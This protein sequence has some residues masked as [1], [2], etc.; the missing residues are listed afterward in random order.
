MPIHLYWG[1]DLAALQAAVDTLQHKVLD[2][3]W[4]S[5]N[6]Q[7]VD[8][9]DAEAVAAAFIAVRT[10]PFGA[11]GR[12]VHVQN[13]PLC[14][15]C[16]AELAK[17]L[18]ATLPRIPPDCHL[19]L[20]SKGKPDARLKT[21]K[22]LQKEATVK[23]FQQP[24]VWDTSGQRKMVQQAVKTAGL[25]IEP[26]AVDALAEAIGSDSLRLV[27][28]LEKLSLHAAGGTV[29]LAA[30]RALV[31]TTSQTS[32]Q[33]GEALLAND[34]PNVLQLLDE[35]LRANEPPLRIH[36]SLTAQV[37]GWLWV[38]V[39]DAAGER[40]E[41]QIAKAAGI[42]NPRRVYVLRRQLGGRSPQQV[43]RLLAVLLDLE[44]ALKRGVAPQ[45]AFRDCFLPLLAKHPV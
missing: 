45:Q 32:L 20:T 11:G 37:R 27:Q 8:G 39:M 10:P 41:R 42:G 9:K 19:L 1:D 12:L 26:A 13:S 24:A 31:G 21:T 34:I 18:L 16:P 7:R 6:L 17:E 29:S 4:E 38:A 23:M 40:D 44:W 5:F 22:L 3:T 2:T 30:V 25:S 15:S 35:L 14:E 43:Q 36:A 28:E 33:V